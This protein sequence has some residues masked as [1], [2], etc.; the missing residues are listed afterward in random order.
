MQRQGRRRTPNVLTSN[1]PGV[2]VKGN[3]KQIAQKYEQ[4][5]EEAPTETEAENLRQHAEHHNREHERKTQD[6]KRNEQNR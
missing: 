3:S 6:A 5:A 1:G 4:L 2:R